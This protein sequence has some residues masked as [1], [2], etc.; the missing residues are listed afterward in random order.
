[1][2]GRGRKEGK[3]WI[4][5]EHVENMWGKILSGKI[6][7]GLKQLFWTL[8]SSLVKAAGVLVEHVTRNHDHCHC[9]SGTGSPH[10]SS[11]FLAISIYLHFA[12]SLGG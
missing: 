2:G 1:M 9:I 12:N 11:L 4:I 5:G 7:R 8:V 10:P 6:C 3:T